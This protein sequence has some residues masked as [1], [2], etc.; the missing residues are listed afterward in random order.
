MPCRGSILLSF[1]WEAPTG[2]NSS[3]LELRG[4]R[5]ARLTGM[6]NDGGVSA[7]EVGPGSFSAAELRLSI[8]LGYRGRQRV[9]CGRHRFAGGVSLR[10]QVW[11]GHRTEC[12][13]GLGLTL[14]LRFAL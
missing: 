10:A 1:E 6:T 3:S 4:R 13:L 9:G 7:G 5:K 8:P 12:S 2:A 14:V 11:P